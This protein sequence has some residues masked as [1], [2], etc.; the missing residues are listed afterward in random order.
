MKRIMFIVPYFGKWPFWFEFFL[1]S[2]RYNPTVNWLLISENPTPVNLPSNVIYKKISQDEYANFV[3]KKLNIEFHL[4]RPYKLCDLKPMYGYLHQ[5][6]LDNYDFWGFCDVDVIFGDIRNFLTESILENDVI[7]C[8]A[9]R[10]SGH[11]SLFRNKSNLRNAFKNVKRWEDVLSDEKNHQFDEK[12]FSKLFIKY[13]NFP[14]WIRHHIPGYNKLG[15][16][17]YF[18][19]CYS[20]PNCRINWEDGS[21]VF[22]TEWYWNRGTLT[23]N[24]SKN[25]FIYFHFLHWKQEYWKT[26]YREKNGHLK[27]GN[28]NFFR[29]NNDCKKFMVDKNGFHQI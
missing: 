14:T 25:T 21:R 7:S 2:C 9:T 24:R 18:K 3:S 10:I 26:D 22:P 19:E 23:N 4:R 11:F 6:D 27:P 28:A 13:K 1:L 8:H 15:V 20:T 5:E 12:A 29:I 16:K 17:C